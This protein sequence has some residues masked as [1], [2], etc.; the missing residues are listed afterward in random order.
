[1]RAPSRRAMRSPRARHAFSAD[2]QTWHT[3]QPYVAP[4]P[5]TFERLAGEVTAKFSTCER[6]KL[7]IDEKSKALTHIISAVDAATKDEGC[8]QRKGDDLQPR[9]RVICAPAVKDC[10]NCKWHDRGDTIVVKLAS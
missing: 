6:P 8:S 9:C 5:R 2:G 3:V 4:Y 7:I 10:V 1:M